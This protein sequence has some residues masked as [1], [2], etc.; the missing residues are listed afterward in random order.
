MMATYLD[1]EWYSIVVNFKKKSLKPLYVLSLSEFRIFYGNLK[2]KKHRNVSNTDKPYFSGNRSVQKKISFGCVS[3]GL[4]FF[5]HSAKI[6]HV[7]QYHQSSLGREIYF[8]SFGIVWRLGGMINIVSSKEQ[9]HPI[10]S[11]KDTNLS[12]QVIML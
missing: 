9:L 8:F 5:L 1:F 3:F 12:Y 7:V 4:N 2:A 10:F 11:D 6:W